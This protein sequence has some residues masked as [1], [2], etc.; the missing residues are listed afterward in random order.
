MVLNSFLYDRLAYKM[1]WRRPPWQQNNCQKSGKRG[2]NQEK[3]GKREKLVMFFHFAPPDRYGWLRYCLN[4]KSAIPIFS[5]MQIF[6]NRVRIAYNSCNDLPG[7]VGMGKFFNA[8]NLG[9]LTHTFMYKFTIV[10][11][12]ILRCNRPIFGISILVFYCIFNV[13]YSVFKCVCIIRSS[14][15][16]CV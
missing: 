15:I 4:K 11:L 14:F 16:W 2:R 10:L 5:S 9:C 6:F 13:F 7:D 12:W 8:S 3:S 1:Q